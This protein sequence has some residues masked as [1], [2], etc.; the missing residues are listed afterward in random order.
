MNT[1]VATGR[2]TASVVDVVIT[3]RFPRALPL[4]V[5]AHSGAHTATEAAGVGA[6]PA[7]VD[8][9]K[10]LVDAGFTVVAPSAGTSTYGGPQAQTRTGDAITYGRT[11]PAV[12]SAP[13][14][15]IGNSQGSTQMLRYATINPSNTACVVTFNSVVSLTTAYVN[16]I[17]GTRAGI[18]TIYG[19]TYPTPLPAGTDP[20]PVGIPQM[21]THSSDDLY[22]TTDNAGTAYL[23]AMGSTATEV[24]VGALGH[25]NASIAA[26]NVHAIFNFVQAHT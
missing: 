3:P 26:V 24:N 14:V 8:V 15:L 12:T 25:S 10:R 4:V 21:I 22:W 17:A 18:G 5:F 20:N 1:S 23:S 13:V 9:L 11:L 6:F 7:V 2:C 16:D 19:V